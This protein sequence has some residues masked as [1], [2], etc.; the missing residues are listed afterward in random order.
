MFPVSEKQKPSRARRAIYVR[1]E[2]LEALEVQATA[3]V[4]ELLGDY[5]GA[6]RL[7]RTEAGALHWRMT[8]APVV[9]ERLSAT[10]Q[11][12]IDSAIRTLL[13]EHAS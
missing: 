3:L 6:V 1:D 9:E 4:R 10:Q 11:K 13:A 5:P 8:A 2:Q 12:K 7:R